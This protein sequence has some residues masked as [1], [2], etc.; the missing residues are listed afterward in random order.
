M[1]NL[2]HHAFSLYFSI[3]YF[4]FDPGLPTSWHVV[5]IEAFR[6]EDA[7]TETRP[8]SAVAVDGHRLGLL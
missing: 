5:N 3:G 4:A 6:L 1:S 2:F 7:A 8:V